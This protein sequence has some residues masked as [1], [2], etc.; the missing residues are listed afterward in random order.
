LL[1][2][3]DTALVEERKSFIA[4]STDFL[5]AL[6]KSQ[7]DKDRAAAGSQKAL[8]DAELE[9]VRKVDGASQAREVAVIDFVKSHLAPDTK[10]GP[11]PLDR[12]AANTCGQDSY[13]VR[14]RIQLALSERGLYTGAIDGQM[15][16][17]TVEGLRKFQVQ[18]SLPSTGTADSA[19]LE[20]LGLH[21]E[22]ARVE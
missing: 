1:S 2:T 18:A 9:F 11:S 10:Q 15:G 13:T 8:F 17:K 21:C 6:T 14:R 4:K 16:A 3:H 12:A 7:V 5:A 19:T 22:T 20:K